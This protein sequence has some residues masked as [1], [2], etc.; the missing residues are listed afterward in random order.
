MILAKERIVIVRQSHKTGNQTSGH[1]KAI[2]LGQVTR[3]ANTDQISLDDKR[4]GFVPL[5]QK[6]EE[7]H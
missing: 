6:E 7:K 4:S 1:P 2:S 5:A 3:R